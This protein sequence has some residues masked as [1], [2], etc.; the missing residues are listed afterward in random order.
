VST[1]LLFALTGALLFLALSLAPAWAQ[2]PGVITGRVI[3][4][5]AGEAPVA[6]Q[7]VVLFAFRGQERLEPRVS[8]TDAGGM[9]RF[10]G[11]LPDGD[12]TYVVATEFGSLPYI[13]DRATLTLESP[14]AAVDVAVFEPT[15]SDADI[16]LASATLL[17]AGVDAEAG[18]VQMLEMMTVANVGSRTVVAAAGGPGARP[19]TVRLTVPDGAMDVAPQFGLR[20]EDIQRL[21]DGLVA[22]TPVPPGRWQVV[23]SYRL[24]YRSSRLQLSKA[25]PYPADELR[26]LSADQQLG[27]ASP[28]LAPAG[29]IELQGRSYRALAGRALPAGTRIAIELTGLPVPATEQGR[30]Q[31]AEQRLAAGIGAGVLALVLAGGLLAR[32]GLRLGRGAQPAQH[33]AALSAVLEE[34][35]RLDD[36]YAGGAVGT[37]Q[38]QRERAALKQRALTLAAHDGDTA[39]ILVSRPAHAQ[40]ASP[41]RDDRDLPPTTPGRRQD[42]E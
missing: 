29:T 1:R 42:G 3:N 11:L 22:T 5:T 40:T 41:S 25:I 34:L 24:N 27:L 7:R 20:P 18:Q 9:F 12:I 8:T 23:L 33:D 39:A 15:T 28:Q 37:E 32:T 26:V 13:S 30:A 35:A 19:G 4:R 10:D 16:R 17:I 6:G 21:P 31:L 36:A 38:Y 2:S 14:S